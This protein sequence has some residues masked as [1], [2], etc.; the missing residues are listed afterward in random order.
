[1]L[2]LNFDG[3]YLV[4][5][6]VF[7]SFIFPYSQ[8]D[9]KP[10]FCIILCKSNTAII[11][12][13]ADSLNIHE[14]TGKVPIPIPASKYRQCNPSDLYYFYQNYTQIIRL[15]LQIIHD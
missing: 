8:S 4:V 9:R 11:I 13:V 2:L 1:M 12:K 7:G 15:L 10:L 3:N 6:E 14:V 5:K